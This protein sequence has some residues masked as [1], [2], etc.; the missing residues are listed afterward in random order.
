MDWKRNSNKE[1]TDG[2]KHDLEM[3]LCD[4]RTCIYRGDYARCYLDIY[5]FCRHYQVNKQPEKENRN[6]YK[7]V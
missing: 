5:K 7:D 1:I 4:C 6:I 2:M 3:V